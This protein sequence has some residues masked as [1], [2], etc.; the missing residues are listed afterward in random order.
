M[1]LADKVAIITGAGRGIS[2]RAIAL[3]YAREGAR[4][5]LVARSP[6]EL[7]DTAREAQALGV[8]AC[9]IPT[10]VAD[11]KQVDSMVAQVIDQYCTVDI[12]VNNAGIGGPAG[13]LQDND[14]DYWVQTIQVNLIG[15]YLC[16]RA[17]LPVMVKQDRGQIIN[18]GGGGDMEASPNFSAY[19]SSKAAMVRLTEVLALE[20]AETNVRVNSLRPGSVHTRLMEE[21]VEALDALGLNELRDQVKVTTGG[22]GEPIEITANLAV[23]LASADAGNLSGRLVATRDDITKWSGRIPE[24]MES[25]AYLLRRVEHP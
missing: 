19:S 3:A 17:V 14:P 2:D 8:P 12:L 10:D 1:R 24:I 20:L 9:V 15:A 4:L 25:E 7:E 16:C 18:I 11:R 5:A 6:N 22:G 23:F 21:E 13:A